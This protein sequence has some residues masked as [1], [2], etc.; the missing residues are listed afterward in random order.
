MSSPSPSTQ[1]T[2]G[3]GEL[4]DGPIISIASGTPTSGL[5]EFSNYTH[6]LT[7]WLRVDCGG[8]IYTRSGTAEVA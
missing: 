5:L 4:S 1:V 7:Q 6:K 3:R 8:V 2:L